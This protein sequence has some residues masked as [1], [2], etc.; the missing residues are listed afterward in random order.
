MGEAF[1]RKI[2]KK[3]SRDRSQTLSLMERS[4]YYPLILV[5]EEPDGSFSGYHFVA[6]TL[7][8][9][10]WKGKWYT[11]HLVRRHTVQADSWEEA[12]KSGRVHLC[13]MMMLEAHRIQVLYI[14][15]GER[16]DLDPCQLSEEDRVREML[17]L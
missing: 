13:R 9:K 16:E 17:N 6:S 2:L 11:I 7:I 8:R 14:I 3:V 1:N 4:G 5:E 12:E 10:E 15:T